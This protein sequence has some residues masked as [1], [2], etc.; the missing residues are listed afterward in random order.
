MQYD[1]S[2]ITTILISFGTA[3]ATGLTTWIFSRKMYKK[4]VEKR[5]AEVEANELENVQ[6][7]ITIWRNT[8]EGLKA[9][10]TELRAKIERYRTL[11]EQ[12]RQ[13]NLSLKLTKHIKHETHFENPDTVGDNADS[14]IVL[15]DSPDVKS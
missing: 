12:L 14:S 7:A 3:F 10:I 15:N 8:A 9:E 4:D 6:A 2:W 1:N 11:V 5:S 13:E